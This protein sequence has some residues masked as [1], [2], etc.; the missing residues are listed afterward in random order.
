MFVAVDG[1][2][3]EAAQP[4]SAQL[5]QALPSLQGRHFYGYFDFV[6]HRY[7]ACVERREG[8]DAAALGLEEGELPG[9]SYLRARLRGE[10]PELYGQIGPMFDALSAEAGDLA[11]RDRPWLEFY[12]RHDQVDVLMPVTE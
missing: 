2:P 5:E 11:D 4:A 3:D 10:P 12:R 8:D 9:G 6:N 7:V 1:P